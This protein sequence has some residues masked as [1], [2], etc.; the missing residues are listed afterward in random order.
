MSSVACGWLP[1]GA[2]SDGVLCLRLAEQCVAWSRKWF[3]SAEGTSIRLARD[4]EPA[5]LSVGA[6][7][8]ATSCRKLVLVVEKQQLLR[9]GLAMLGLKNAGMRI[10]SPDH[11]LLRGLASACI[12]DLMSIVSNVLGVR[13]KS[14]RVESAEADRQGHGCMT[15][16]IA[17]GSAGGHV[18]LFVRRDSAV[19]AR[20][21]LVTSPARQLP[22]I[23]SRFD[24]IQRQAVRVGVHVGTG[25]IGLSEIPALAC[26]DVLVLDRNVS[27]SFG[28]AIDGIADPDAECD[29]ERGGSVMTLR[30]ARIGRGSSQ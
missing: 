7:C 25:S 23:G 3:G 22:P 16:R 11:T 20:Q 28:L 9:I 1:P 6:D 4:H 29:I 27:D 14:S 8:W 5:V 17:C 26:G 24:A 21:A 15:Y 12:D 18:E 19:W 30:I 2:L 13:T 10:K